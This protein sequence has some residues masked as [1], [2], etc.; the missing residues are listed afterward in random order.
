MINLEALKD[1]VNSENAPV[2][3]GIVG[4]VALVGI[5]RVTKHSYKVDANKDSITVAPANTTEAKKPEESKQ[6]E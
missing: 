4:I 3:A 2:I 1:M 5:D 6:A